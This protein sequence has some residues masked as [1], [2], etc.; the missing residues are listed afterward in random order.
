[1]GDELQGSIARDMVPALIMPAGPQARSPA[2]LGGRPARWAAAAAP[3]AP[4]TVCGVLCVVLPA[5]PSSP[6]SKLSES[7][8]HPAPGS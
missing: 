2:Q 1:M 7:H 5:M 6:H 8:C 4:V 3:C